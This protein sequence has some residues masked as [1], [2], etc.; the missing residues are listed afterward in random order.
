MS[1]SHILD[2]KA[3]IKRS[4]YP[5]AVREDLSP[6]ARRSQGRIW[7]VAFEPMS[8]PCTGGDGLSRIVRVSK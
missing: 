3:V 6:A 8:E 5:E 2:L 1:D 7:K 4:T